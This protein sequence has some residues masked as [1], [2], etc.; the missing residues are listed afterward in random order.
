M[1]RPSSRSPD[2]SDRGIRGIGI[3]ISVHKSGM[4]R[5]GVYSAAMK[6]RMRALFNGGSENEERVIKAFEAAVIAEERENRAKENER[7][8]AA[9]LSAKSED[10]EFIETTKSR[11]G[12]GFMDEMMNDTSSYA[13]DIVTIQKQA[14]IE[15]DFTNDCF[16]YNLAKPSVSISSP[17]YK[18]RTDI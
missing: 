17:A 16:Y 8:L 5:R 14:M 6:R 15:P 1:V 3:P 12:E 4:K 18:T 2:R 13:R 11:Y 7:K 10:K 9:K